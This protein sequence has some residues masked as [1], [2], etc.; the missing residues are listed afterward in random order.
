MD[1]CEFCEAPYKH[2]RIFNKISREHEMR[3]HCK[4]CLKL[5]KRRR[6][7]EEQLVES[8]W[9]MFGRKYNRQYFDNP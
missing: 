3:S 4:A 1:H 5:L 6:W 9:E 8:S 2:K 7:L